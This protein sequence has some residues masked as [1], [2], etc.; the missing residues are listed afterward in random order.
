MANAARG[1]EKVANPWF[2]KKL[3]HF[4]KKALYP[5]K[6]GLDSASYFLVTEE[7]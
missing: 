7:Q 1:N 5:T 6:A 3:Q 4:L 2:N